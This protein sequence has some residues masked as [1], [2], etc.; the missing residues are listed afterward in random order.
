MPQYGSTDCL[1]LRSRRCRKLFGRC[2]YPRIVTLPIQMGEN[3]CGI[4]EVQSAFEAGACDL[5]MP[6][7]MKIGG[8][9]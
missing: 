2:L 5:A 7:V 8:V 6:E 3:L 4:E 9:T 1:V